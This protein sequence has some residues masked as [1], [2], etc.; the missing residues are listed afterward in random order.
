MLLP[1]RA[2]CLVAVLV[3]SASA[4]RAAT[5]IEKI[6]SLG[7]LYSFGNGV[8]DAGSVTGL[9]WLPDGTRRA[10]L[11]VPGSGGVPQTLDTLG[12]HFA[13]GSGINNAGK[14]V[15]GST[16]G[17]ESTGGPFLYSDGSTQFLGTLGGVNG[18]AHSINESGMIT[19]GSSGR[20]FLYTGTPG[21]DGHMVD[22]GSLAGTESVGNGINA[23]GQVA[24]T[25]N[26]D[27]LAAAAMRAFRYVGTPGVDGAM[28]PLGSLGGIS[29]FGMAIN[30]AG[31]VA[32]Y[33]G[34]SLNVAEHAFLYTGTPGQGGA[35]ADLGTLG[36]PNSRGFG[37]NNLGQV[38]GESQTAGGVYHA[39][40]YTGGQMIDLDTWLD[41]T[42]PVAG[43]HWT[44]TF[45]SDIGNTGYIS[46]YGIYDGNT[47]GFLIDG[48]SLLPEP[49]TLGLLGLGAVTLVR[50]RR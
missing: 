40:I 9:L 37:I 34:V 5:V 23:S 3:A 6:D 20:A 8:N 13:G 46:G 18:G 45:A 42:D 31:Q 22:L 4:A 30:D 16:F 39:F 38:V 35:M 14:I 1:S 26:S 17:D 12:G 47:R 19:G 33:S 15:G 36:G 44:L 29:S 50:R 25:S 24:G 28:Q 49:A 11:Y 32:G 41:A 7:G 2:C 27:P 10:F 48:S 21:V 43:A